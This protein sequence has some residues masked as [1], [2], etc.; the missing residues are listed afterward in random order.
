M[1]MAVI[2]GSNSAGSGIDNHTQLFHQLFLQWWDRVV[3]SNTRSKLT[4]E[5]S[6]LGG[7]GSDFFTF[8][9]QNF[10][11]MN[12]QPDIIISELSLNDYGHLYGKTAKPMEL[13]AG[14]VLFAE[15]L[16]VLSL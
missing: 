5:N 12:D 15:H 7:T 8:C 1:K 10:L 14:R 6:S 2:G 4:V 9:L 3:F 16:G 11:P 13:L